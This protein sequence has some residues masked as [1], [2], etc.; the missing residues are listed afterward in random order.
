MSYQTQAQA[1]LERRKR[2]PKTDKYSTFQKQYKH[3]PL[4]FVHDC[5]DF[6]GDGP[7]PY[8]D[9]ILAGFVEHKRVAVRG[10]HGMG[11]TALAS[12][13]VLWAVLTE[14]DCK[15]PTT[16]SAWRQ[17][18]KFLWPEIRKW[19]QWLRWQKIG[20][21]PFNQHTELH[22]RSLTRGETCEAFAV[23]CTNP[24]TIEGAHA[25]RV[26]YVY[27]EA[28]AVPNDTFDATEGAFSAAGDDTDDEAFALAISTPG[29]PQ[30]RFYDIHSRKPGY[31]DWWTR[32]VTLDEAIE[33]GRISRQWA[34]QRKRQWGEKSAV[35]QNRVLGEFAASSADTL[36]PL[37]W[38]EAANERWREWS[39]A[40]K[41]T[42]EGVR[43]YG[44]DV[45]RYGDDKSALAEGV[46]DCVTWIDVW[47]KFDTMETA[48]R[49]RPK[50]RGARVKVDVI[51]IGAGTLDRLRELGE[52]AI[53]VN[54]GAGTDCT[55][56]SGEVE[57]LNVRAAAWWGLRERLQPPSNV[58]LPPLDGL[59]GDLTAGKY[60]YTSTGK[61]KIEDKNNI[62][63]RLG[64]S[65]NEGDAV[66]LLFWKPKRPRKPAGK[67]VEGVRL[68]QQSRRPSR[69]K[70]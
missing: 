9:E 37:A 31:E 55:D 10:P 36:I 49:V 7:T 69:W 66:T 32:H 45:A 8:Q 16:A 14:D 2:P 19:A 22:K 53:G 39:D 50:L 46:G 26:V 63:L 13:I 68:H 30:G 12:W 6:D 35:Y 5:I 17:L 43:R 54:F 3:D 56:E 21:R 38:V 23:A 51:G 29:S 64:R 40:G 48:G 15:C 42:P 47:G 44:L 70:R 60:G 4:E 34:D 33:A 18:T 62:R 57:M 1:E 65:P 58:M 11:K 59:T 25:H 41:L 20:R 52:D 61:L 27:D 67:Q 28:K 24:A